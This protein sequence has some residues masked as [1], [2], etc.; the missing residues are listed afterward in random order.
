MKW[1]IVAILACVV[2]YNYLNLKYRKPNPAHRPYEDN[3]ER[4]NVM[5]LLAAGY[6]RLPLEAAPAD[7]DTLSDRD[8]LAPAAP[9]GLPARLGEALVEPP[10]LPARLTA[11]V[12]A[13]TV[14]ADA[15]YEIT[16]AGQHPLPAEVLLRPMAYLRDDELTIVPAYETRGSF[17]RPRDQAVVLRLT[18]PAHSLRPGTY[19]TSLVTAEA[20]HT[21]T[22]EVR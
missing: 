12:A 7:D 21:W 19:R 2:L 16:F 6:Q 4:A 14:A 8:H 10:R 15:A 5:R 18:L 17:L 11:L 1:I 20:T 9:G 13:A 3:K 22:L